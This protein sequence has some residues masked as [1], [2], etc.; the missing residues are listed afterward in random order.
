MLGRHNFLGQ[1]RN[2]EMKSFD[3]ILAS[4]KRSWKRRS[5]GQLLPGAEDP[6]GF[7]YDRPPGGGMF[8]PEEETAPGG[9]A[10]GAA[11]QGDVVAA[12][13]VP[14]PD[15][16]PVT[17]LPKWMMLSQEEQERI[18]QEGKERREALKPPSP[19]PGSAAARNKQ[20]I[21]WSVIG[22]VTGLALLGLAMAAA[23]RAKRKAVTA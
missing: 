1:A 5:L 9:A 17:G 7:P 19:P 14:D 4:D 18:F 16:D 12:G 22:G 2:G 10:E 8:P 11:P 6:F 3:D 13:L 21:K 23:G 15:I 20:I